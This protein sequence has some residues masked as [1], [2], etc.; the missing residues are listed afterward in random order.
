MRWGATAKVKD[1]ESKYSHLITRSPNKQN[2]ANYHVELT[3]TSST[4][5]G[6]S[7]LLDLMTVM[8]ASRILSEE[9]VLI[10]NRG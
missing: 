6:G 10:T 9:M 1:L 2:P 4:T 8:K 5:S 3:Q 7:H